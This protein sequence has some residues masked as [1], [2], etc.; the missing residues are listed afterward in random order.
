MLWFAVRNKLEQSPSLRGVST[1]GLSLRTHSQMTPTEPPSTRRKLF[2]MHLCALLLVS[3]TVFAHAQQAPAHDGWNLTWSDEFNG[4]ENAPPDPAKWNFE[5]GGKGFGNQELE[6]YTGRLVN[7]R[8]HDG[9]LVI[10][11]RKEDFT[12]SDGIAR[13]YTSARLRTLGLFSQAYGRFEARMQL[14]TG[15]GIWP[16]FWL[17][18]ND[19]DSVGWPRCGEVD[20]MENIGDP[21]TIYSTLHGPGYSGSKGISAR[22]TLPHGQSVHNAFHLYAVE[23]A[24]RDIKFFF[25]D[26]LIAEGTPSNLPPGT[27]WVYDHPFFLLL[28]LA[29]GGGWPGTPDESTAFPQQMLVDY[30]RVYTK[31]PPPSARSIEESNPTEGPRRA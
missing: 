13:H 28:N 11:A 23:W 15:K 30:V 24:P 3:I 31:N 22:Y 2:P 7:A 19:I 29:V 21:A 9:N 5:T 25:D 12:G 17:L 20:V 4:P 10:T 27:T 8:Q 18:G 16:A 6:T 1:P 26:H 14:P